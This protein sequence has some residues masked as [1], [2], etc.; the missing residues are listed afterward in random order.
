MIRRCPGVTWLGALSAFD[1]YEA[2][3]NRDDA[4][5]PLMLFAERGSVSPPSRNLGNLTAAQPFY[6]TFNLL[7]LFTVRELPKFF[8]S[9]TYG[10]YFPPVSDTCHRRVKS[11]SSRD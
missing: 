7:E 6:V 2:Y 1:Y 11:S 9:D 5:A 8:K 4:S 3:T 10:S